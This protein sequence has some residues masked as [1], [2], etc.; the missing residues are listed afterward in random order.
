MCAHDKPMAYPGANP[1]ENPDD[2]N[3][4]LSSTIDEPFFR[5]LARSIQEIINPPKLPPLVLT[6]KPV[7]VREIW[8]FYGG[9]GR[10]AGMTSF[11]V[12][13]GVIALLFLLGT[14]KVVQQ[15]VKKQ[16]ELI[17]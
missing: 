11:L 13:V 9:Q 3:L 6:S 14:N 10:R 2:L 4:F 16:I 8:G 1:S 7:A 17:A 5:S 15:V 12:H